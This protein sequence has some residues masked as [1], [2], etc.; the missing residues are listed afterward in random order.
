V[1]DAGKSKDSAGL[2]PE[3][4]RRVVEA[5]EESIPLYDK[6]NNIVSFGKAQ[7]ARKFAVQ[8][9][10]LSDSMVILDAGIGPGTTSKLIMES[11][12]PR[13]LVGFDAS[14]KQL[15]TAKFALDASAA[16]NLQL[17][18]GAFEFLPFREGV[19]DAIITCYAL[20][21]SLDLSRS[22]EEYHRVCAQSGAFADV[23]LG[24]PDNGFKRVGS[25]FYIRYLMPLI[26]EAAIIG[27]IK[28]NPW[29]M[30]VPTYKPLPT[31]NALQS[32][33]RSRFH[34]MEFKEFLLGGIVVIIGRKSSD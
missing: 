20:R 8:K 29:R 21:D 17:V 30:I 19:F 10:Q 9:L 15:K 16:T 23:D 13:L 11:A 32:Q 26:A 22:V 4:S 12:K 5:I 14:A 31:N 6:V 27:R 1:V 25:T 18:R 3:T 7:V 24:K 34:R 33:V 2:S 28:G